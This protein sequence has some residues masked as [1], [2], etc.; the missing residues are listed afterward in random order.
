MRRREVRRGRSHGPVGV[1]PLPG[2]EEAGR[3][4]DDAAGVR[5]G[6]HAGRR[7]PLPPDARG[8]VHRVGGPHHG[9]PVH[10]DPAEAL[11]A[12]GAPSS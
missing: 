12:G 11:R 10:D 8:L 2:H 4:A 7:G 5:G 9:V 3:P 6:A 1:D